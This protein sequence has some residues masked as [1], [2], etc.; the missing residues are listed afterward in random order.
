MP[1]TPPINLFQRHKWPFSTSKH[2][3]EYDMTN[4]FRASHI[5][6]IISPAFRAKKQQQDIRHG[7]HY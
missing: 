4:I 7:G 5:L 6:Q 3:A 2:N 1:I